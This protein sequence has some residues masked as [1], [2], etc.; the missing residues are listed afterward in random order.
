MKSTDHKVA[1]FDYLTNEVAN[2]L[3]KRSLPITFPHKEFCQIYCQT[4]K[5][6]K[7]CSTIANSAVMNIQGS[8]YQLL[9]HRHRRWPNLHLRMKWSECNVLSRKMYRMTALPFLLQTTEISLANIFFRLFYW[10]TI[11]SLILS[12]TRPEKIIRKHILPPNVLLLNFRVPDQHQRTNS[13]FH[14]EPIQ[15]HLKTTPPASIA[16]RA[17]S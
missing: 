7:N 13:M 10:Q 9:H 4:D 14:P 2:Y 8:L 3:F 17:K 11:L 5:V 6:C 12:R 1:E 16:T 15:Q